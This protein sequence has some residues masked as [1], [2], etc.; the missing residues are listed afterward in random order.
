MLKTKKN[1]TNVQKQSET[2]RCTHYF[3]GGGRG[4]EAVILFGVVKYK[5][6]VTTFCAREKTVFTLCSQ[7]LAGWL[8]YEKDKQFWKTEPHSGIWTLDG[9]AYEERKSRVVT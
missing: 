8:K 5:K 9:S 4:E 6:N 7:W 1:K 3:Q 2:D